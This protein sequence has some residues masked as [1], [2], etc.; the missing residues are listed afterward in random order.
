MQQE[1]K[2]VAQ[3]DKNG[4]K[5]LDAAERKAARE[6]LATQP[7]AGFGGAR[8]VRPRRRPI[9][10]APGRKLA[11]AD[12]KRIPPPR[13]STTS[14]TIRTLFLQFEDER[15]GTGAGGIQQHRRRS[16]GDAI[17]DGKTYKASACTSAACRRTSW[18]RKDASGRSTCRSISPTTSRR[19]AATRR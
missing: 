11:P 9:R 6:W 13:R 5:R 14:A 16:S 1:R 19:S 8:A 4:D 12:V 15:L 18:C 10:P 3:F 7:A 17:V 2:L